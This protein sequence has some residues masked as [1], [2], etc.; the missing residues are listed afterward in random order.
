MEDFLQF[1]TEKALILM[2][3][4]F[5]IGIFLKKTPHISDW[6]IPWILLVVGVTGAIF[7]TGDTIDGIIQG[8]LVTGSTVLTHQLYKQTSK[9]DN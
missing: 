4:L 5:I 7:L 1:I 9:K 3:A 8:I 2:P 6:M